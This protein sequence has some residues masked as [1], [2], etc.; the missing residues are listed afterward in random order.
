MDA[1][2]PLQAQNARKDFDGMF[3]EQIA[4]WLS[5]ANAS[6]SSLDNILSSSN[7]TS[8]SSNIT[9][10]SSDIT[11][12]STPA[13][14]FPAGVE[15]S[16]KRILASYSD[17]TGGPICIRFKKCSIVRAQIHDRLNIF[18]AIAECLG[19]DKDDIIRDFYAL[20]EVRYIRRSTR[21]WVAAFQFHMMGKDKKKIVV[22]DNVCK[23]YDYICVLY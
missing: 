4:Y 11:S 14:G 5:N 20:K 18:R 22:S 7:I 8:S 9:S 13:G 12:S 15:K 17:F 21:D 10:S 2:V 19:K 23:S 1:I 16:Y 3:Q 6:S